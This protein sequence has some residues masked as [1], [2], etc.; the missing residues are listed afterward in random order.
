MK[1]SAVGIA[2]VNNMK[3]IYAAEPYSTV[4]L[5]L[6]NLIQTNFTTYSAYKCEQIVNNVKS[7]YFFHKGIE[8]CAH[9]WYNI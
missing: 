6:P 8:K 2:N 3:A 9:L 5:F 4:I 7:G 1:K